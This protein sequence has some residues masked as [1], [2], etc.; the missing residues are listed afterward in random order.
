M[1]YIKSLILSSLLIFGSASQAEILEEEFSMKKAPQVIAK[2]LDRELSLMDKALNEQKRSKKEQDL[3]LK[4][5]RFTFYPLLKFDAHFLEI[6]LRPIFEFRWERDYR[7]GW[8]AY[9]PN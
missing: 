2:A 7:N 6:K 9:R 3:Y 8:E 5:V 4:R 1:K